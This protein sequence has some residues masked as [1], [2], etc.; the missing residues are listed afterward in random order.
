[1]SAL[2]TPIRGLTLHRGDASH[3]YAVQDC[4]GGNEAT[5]LVGCCTITASTLA[6]QRIEVWRWR[7]RS[8]RTGRFYITHKYLTEAEALTIDPLAVRIDWLAEYRWVPTR[9]QRRS[10]LSGGAGGT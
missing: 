6:M 7:V 1:M 4:G 5:N 8:K 10:S 3:V 9:R 2:C